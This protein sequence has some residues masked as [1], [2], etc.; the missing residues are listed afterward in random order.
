MEGRREPFKD[1]LAHMLGAE[2]DSKSIKRFARAYPDRW[3]NTIAVFARLAGYNDKMQIEASLL[4]GITKMSD[5]E[6]DQA[7]HEISS[8]STQGQSDRRSNPPS[9]R[10]PKRL[11]KS[12][13]RRSRE[14]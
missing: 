5:S 3:S 7:L 12:I 13:E 11:S 2:P 1:V 8:E 9:E 4:M 10:P 14:I 6:L